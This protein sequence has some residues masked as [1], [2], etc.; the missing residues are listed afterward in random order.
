[1]AKKPTDVEPTEEDFEVVRRRLEEEDPRDA[2]MY[3]LAKHEARARI[4]RERA[5]RPGILQRI[6]RFGRA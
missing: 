4:A 6:L 3:A 1:M 5:A 2:L